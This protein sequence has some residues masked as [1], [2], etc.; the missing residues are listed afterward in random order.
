MDHME[1]ED[2]ATGPIE[3]LKEVLPTLNEL[4]AHDLRD[5]LYDKKSHIIIQLRGTTR[6]YPDGV[7]MNASDFHRWQK[8]ARAAYNIKE[9]AC[10]LVKTH[11]HR[12]S[13]E[14]NHQQSL[15]A[16]RMRSVRVGGHL[17][18]LD[19]L[20]RVALK[21]LQGAELPEDERIVLLAAKQ[22]LDHA[23]R[24]KVGA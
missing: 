5:I 4:E 19:E 10:R 14:A 3:E 16:E 24:Q 15:A 2:L 17:G 21:H 8:R 9:V 13:V 6:L 7:E 12:L 20:Y 22:I 18:V 23:K 1:L 11:I